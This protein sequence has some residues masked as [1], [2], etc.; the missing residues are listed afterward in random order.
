MTKLKK[1]D[2]RVLAN[3][4]GMKYQSK[5]SWFGYFAKKTQFNVIGA[6]G[7]RRNLAW[8]G[9]ADWGA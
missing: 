1:W 5:R 9:Q 8:V 2:Q 6:W 7:L 3:G 4:N